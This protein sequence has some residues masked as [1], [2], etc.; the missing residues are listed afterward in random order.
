MKEFAGLAQGRVW[1]AVQMMFMDLQQ[2]GT[3]VEEADVSKIDEDGNQ[4]GVKIRYKANPVLPR[5]ND[6]MEMLGFTADQMVMT[7][8]KQEDSE[9]IKG[10]LEQESGKAADLADYLEQQKSAMHQLKGAI[11][12]AAIRSAADPAMV[13]HA[14]KVDHKDVTDEKTEHQAGQ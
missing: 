9:N 13:R 6:F 1:Q 3:L 10:F 11:A 5:I 8:A 4:F 2:H 12:K 7:P 14:K